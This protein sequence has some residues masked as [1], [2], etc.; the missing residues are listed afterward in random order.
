M[1]I[2]KALNIDVSEPVELHDGETL[3]LY[4][5]ARWASLLQGVELID[6]KARQLKIDLDNN[7]TWM[8]PLALQKYIDE[9]TPSMVAQI[10]CLKDDVE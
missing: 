8:K 1:K 2:E 3:T 7:K 4:E 9:E 6:K 10:K 5:T